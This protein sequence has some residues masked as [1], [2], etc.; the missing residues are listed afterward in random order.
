MLITLSPAHAAGSPWELPMSRLIPLALLAAIACKKE[1]P[2][3]AP[4]PVG[5]FAELG[6]KSQ[7]YFPPDFEQIET[8]GGPS[9]RKQARQTALE[10]MIS[11][12]RGQREDGVAFPD[13]SIEDVEITLLGRPEKIEAVALKNL[14]LCK[15]VMGAGADTGSWESWLRNLPGK[16]TAG[17]CLV[18]YTYT[19]FDYLDIQTGWQF[20]VPLCQG[21]EVR[22]V[23]TSN[24]RYKLTKDGAW[25]NVAGLEG[26]AASDSAMPCTAEGCFVGMLV[27][28]FT[29]EDGFVEVFPVGV[30]KVYTAPQHGTLSLSINDTTWYDNTW[31]KTGGIEDH[32]GI[33]IYPKE[34]F[35]Q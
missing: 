23:A 8:E 3:P 12:W 19:L 34:E 11:Q 15:Q 26:Q 9:A 2:A 27:G 22:I 30:E 18:P 20:S 13:Q 17:E 7:C 33:T 6:W 14:E 25:I 5:W 35:Q 31:F 29:T 4:P 32:T 16:L 24:D 10:S 28:R 1:A 21:D